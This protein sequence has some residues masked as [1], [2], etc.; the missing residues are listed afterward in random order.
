MGG[1]GGWSYLEI[2]GGDRWMRAQRGSGVVFRATT[3]YCL[4][5]TM[6]SGGVQEATA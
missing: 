1:G 2:R 6:G 5:V 4:V 3:H